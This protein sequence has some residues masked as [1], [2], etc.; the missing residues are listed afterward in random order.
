MKLLG[1]VPNFYINASMSDLYVYS[2]DRSVYL[3]VH[4]EQG[5]AVSFLEIFV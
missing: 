4:W 5:R 1:L 3:S 2:H